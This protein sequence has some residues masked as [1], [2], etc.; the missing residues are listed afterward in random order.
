MVLGKKLTFGLH[1]SDAHM[2]VAI[3]LYTIDL[4]IC[5][6]A[7]RESERERERERE[8]EKK[9]RRERASEGVSE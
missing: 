4:Y 6:H 3:W 9:K 5:I 7:C 2:N 8:R 1:K